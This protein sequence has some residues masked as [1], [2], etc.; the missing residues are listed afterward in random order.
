MKPMSTQLA[1]A[2]RVLGECPLFRGLTVDERNELIARAHLRKFAP[3]D[4]VFLMGSPG[5]SMMAV[6]SGIIRIS[7]PS[8]EG[9]EI[10]LA[11]LEP[12]EI[13]GEI[14]VLDGKQRSADAIA[15][16]ESS[17]LAVL[18]RRDVSS[19]LDRHPSAWSS[20]AGV[21][22]ERLRCTDLQ[23]AEVA[24]MEVPIRLAKALL[25][26]AVP[27]S[28]LK[29]QLEIHLSQRELG[30]IVG[31]TRESVNKCLREWQQAGVVRV[32]GAVIKINDPE[33]LE[34]VADLGIVPGRGYAPRHCRAPIPEIRVGLER[35]RWSA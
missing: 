34:E 12:G 27:T 32:E 30:G 23:F 21:L 1:N 11:M 7:V 31:A 13:F 24:L 2:R 8:P 33:A 20:L 5:D 19:F 29:A 14:A 22:C 16:T 18:T 9:K 10:V 3:G 17:C 35:E 26:L 6:L 4:T 28:G 25:R 15:V